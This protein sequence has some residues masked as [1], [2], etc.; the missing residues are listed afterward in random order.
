MMQKNDDSERILLRQVSEGHRPA[1][2]VLYDRYWKKIYATS[3]HYLKSAEWA[4][5]L[6]QDIFLKIWVKRL[7][8]PEIENFESFL[9]IVARNEIVSAI[10]KRVADAPLR[11]GAEVPAA[12]EPADN[13]LQLKQTEQLIEDAIAQL[14]PQQKLVFLL[15]RRGGLS[16]E[17]IAR[18]LGLNTRTVNNHASRALLHI[19]QYLRKQGH[20]GAR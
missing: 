3:L 13:V 6:V 1:F 10:R 15:T 19:R 8:L 11:D 7:V 17:T 9:F 2:T 20:F 18:R 14:P 12:I 5:D 4:E 16:H